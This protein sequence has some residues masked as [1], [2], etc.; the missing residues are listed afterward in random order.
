M[1]REFEFGRGVEGRE[2]VTGLLREAV[3]VLPPLVLLLELLVVFDLFE[4][5]ISFEREGEI[6]CQGPG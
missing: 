1:E 3:E 2:E 6:F 5:L 4:R